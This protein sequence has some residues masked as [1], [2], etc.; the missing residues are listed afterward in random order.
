MDKNKVIFIT[1]DGKE[2]LFDGSSFSEVSSDDHKNYFN[3][4]VVLPSDIRT[5]GIKV[6]KHSTPEKIQMQSEISI[7]EDGGLDPEIEY[8]ISSFVIPIEDDDEN[9]V[10]TYAVE[11]TTL[12]EKFAPIVEKHKHL[13]LL[14]PSSHR[15]NALYGCNKL[16][17]KND[18]FI[19][20]SETNS[21]AV[22]YKSGQYISTRILPNLNEIATKINRDLPTTIELL[23]TKGV[24]D[25]NYSED[26]FLVMNDIQDQFSNIAERIAHSISHKRGVF[27][28]ETIDRIFLDFE[29]STIPGFL[30][31]FDNYGYAEASKEMLDIFCDIEV[32]LKH[33]VLA[34][35][36]ALCSIQNNIEPVNLIRYERK[37]P[38]LKTKVGLFTM[39]MLSAIILAIAYPAYAL[40]HLNNLDTKEKELSSELQEINTRTKKLQ[41]KLKEERDSRD[42]LKKQKLEL[43]T[44]I[45]SYMTIISTLEKLDK[46]KIL[47]QKMLKD[48]IDTMQMYKLASR[49]LEFKQNSFYNVQIITKPNDRDHIALFIKELI[50]LGYSNVETKKV[51]KNDNYYESFV[52]IRP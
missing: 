18:L 27:K 47:R 31:L 9:F 15:Y 1:S 12:D 23:T 34:A 52:E 2:L 42:E 21:Y 29:C 25:E 20:F 44:E 41:T 38:F 48:I 17:P 35:Q 24:E 16:E 11:A 32:G 45:N 40:V 50:S 14:F 28:L 19:H 51:E 13:D 46:D 3:A 39:V 22:I 36:Y 49:K 33:D 43:N 8:S 10:E 37:P 5:H 26:E 6:S 4:A 30:E 7:F